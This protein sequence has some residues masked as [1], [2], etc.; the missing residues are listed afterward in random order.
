VFSDI[1][2]ND[3]YKNGFRVLRTMNHK[4]YP[5]TYGSITKLIEYQNQL[6][7]VFEHGIGLVTINNSAEYASQILS[8]LTVISDT[9]G[10]QW[11]DSIIQ[12]PSGLYGVDTVAR[13]IWRVKNGEIE[14]L[15]D[16][17]VQEFLNQNISLSERELTPILGIRNVKTFY[18]AFKH[19]IMFT[20][21]DNLY[22]THE[23]S[24]NLCYNEIL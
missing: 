24:W 5:M 3:A 20:F 2:I 23:K 7:V 12:T 8:D 18:N 4:D 21:Y 19:D 11:K 16:F 9:Y 10:S 1:H 15:S 6:I 14:L 22:G 17:K 13:K